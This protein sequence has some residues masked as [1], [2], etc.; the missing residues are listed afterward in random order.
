MAITV[1]I[2]GTDRT[3][4]VVS[5]DLESSVNEIGTGQITTIDRSGSWQPA[6]WDTVVITDNGTTLWRGQI[7]EV[8]TTWSLRY[9]GRLSRA[10]VAD[11]LHV[12]T[13]QLVN[14]ALPS[15]R[16]LKS[17]LQD[18]VAL[19]DD[20]WPITLHPSQADGPTLTELALPWQTVFDALR[21]LSDQTGW[22][23]GIDAQ[24]RLRMWAPGTLP[25]G[26]TF[27]QSN[28]NV[29]QA[30]WTQ[31]LQRDYGN[32]IYVEYGPA[33][34]LEKTDRFDGDGSTRSWPL[35]YAINQGDWPHT[36]YDSADAAVRPVALYPDATFEWTYEIATNTLHQRAS[37]PVLTAGQYVE[38]TYQPGF[39]Q[40]ILVSNTTERTARG[41][42]TRYL[43][44]PDVTTFAEADAYADAIIARGI[45]TPRQIVIETDPISL[46][47]G[48]TVTV[49]LPTLGL[50]SITT[51]VQRTQLSADARFRDSQS[52]PL[53]QLRCELVETL[54]RTSWLDFWRGL[55]GGTGTAVTSTGGISGGG[56][57]SWVTP[58]AIER[59]A[60][61]IPGTS[62]AE[63]RNA[64]YVPIDSTRVPSGIVTVRCEVRRVSGSGSLTPQLR[65][66][67]GS[68][69]GAG[70]PV[71][72]S[73]FTAQTFAATL[74]S[75]L[76]RYVLML[77]G[78]D[79]T[80]EGIVVGTVEAS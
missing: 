36:V 67:G 79:S 70:N 24:D 33:E 59:A 14:W 56:A 75:G 25:S 78:S 50:S 4:Y 68:T 22:I 43:K 19:L 17:I 53:V 76:N 23:V 49:D 42:W 34:I 35:T 55:S 69:V 6:V 32:A 8:E 38:A 62:G 64:I 1:T 40:I 58:L 31:Q 18:I 41:I 61:I 9:R 5:F 74:Q 45:T 44:L 12:T 20:D 63:P 47:P 77:V 80:T 48:T 10:R 52:R 39:P 26:V 54:P 2:G 73:T 30:E 71:T 16:T 66:V 37:D 65:V 72:S 29:R 15:G 13:R 46:V 51:L 60:S 21:Y 57:V 11:R 27:D 3:A 28:R 7:L